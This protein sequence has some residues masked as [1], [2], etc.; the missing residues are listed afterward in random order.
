MIRQVL[1]EIGLFAAPF[2]AYAIFLWATRAGVVDPNSWPLGT[3][4]WLTASAV[5]LVA[6]SFVVL[7]LMS[8][9]PPR[10]TYVPAHMEDGQLVPGT[11][12]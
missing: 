4:A 12:K 8:G 10:S 7:A 9:V 2:V 6:A 11:T 3:V 5:V 1:I